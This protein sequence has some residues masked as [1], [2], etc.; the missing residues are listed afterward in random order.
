M[1]TVNSKRLLAWYAGHQRDLPWRRTSDPYKIWVSEVLLQQTRV[2]QAIPYYHQFLKRFPTLE[3]LA[4]AAVSDVLKAWEGAGYYSRARNLHAAAKMALKRW[5]H[6]PSTYDDWLLLPGV[7]PYIAAAVS[8]IAFGEEKAVLD[9]NV[10]RVTSRLLAEKGDVS[11]PA[12]RKKLRVVV[13][14]GMPLGQG[15]AGDYNQALM[16]LGATVCFPKKPLC[17]RCPLKSECRAFALGKQ[18]IFPVKRKKAAVPHYDIACAVVHRAD[19]RILIC[20]RRP[21]GLLGGLWEFPGGKLEKG[22]SLPEAAARE[23]M[24]ETGIRVAIGGKIAAV[25][26]AYSHF[27]ITLHA[28][29][30]VFV[31]GK[32]CPLGCQNVKW[33]R[34]KA[35]EKYAFPRA[36]RHVLDAIALRRPRSLRWC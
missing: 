13:Q 22:E 36:N 31:S 18:A 12:T 2:D 4:E 19:G 32:A 7:G 33:V 14:S 16:E 15:R 26:H 34:L 30:A 25:K 23:V 17:G 27:R 8:S 6:L 24:E 28:F 21:D 11:K 3:A 5:G 9:G 29:D 10:I 35:L 1:S 20:Q